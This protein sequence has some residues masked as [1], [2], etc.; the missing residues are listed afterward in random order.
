VSVAADRTTVVHERRHRRAHAAATLKVM[1][2]GFYD[3]LRSRWI[4]V[5]TLFF[6][7]V[8][9][10]LLYLGGD[11]GQAL[12]STLNLVLVVVPLV[13]LVLGLSYYYYTRDFVELMLTQP[14]GRTSV[15]L[16]HFLG[17]ALP[18]AGAF[19]VGTG[20]PFLV[21]GAG[22]E[23]DGTVLASLLASGVL[24]SVAFAALGILIA[25]RTEERIKALGIGLAVWLGLTMVY[26]GLLLWFIVVMQAYPV[27]RALIGLS[28]LNPVDLSRILVLLQ[29]DTA[30]L[31]GYTGAVFQRFL[32]SGVGAAAS[33]GAL[34]VWAVV[35]VVLGARAFR[36]KD[37]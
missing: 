5:Y 15:F 29:L 3:L 17:V 34:V 19:L 30:A 32:G 7:A 13:S 22:R 33:L 1:K 28:L 37:F 9:S 18:L 11:V 2:Y 14:I 26:D 12:L 8:T 20:A 4:V 16:G 31:M 10:G 6:L 27:E 35:P 24:I 36:R 25:L 21:F 23:V